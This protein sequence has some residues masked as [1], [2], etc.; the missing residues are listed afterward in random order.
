MMHALVDQAR[1]VPIEAEIERRGIVLKGKTADRCGPCPV[2]NG[3]DRFS[4]NSRKQVFHCRGC[5]VG[6]D[7]IAMTQHID[8]CAF[9]AAVET[10]TGDQLR[11]TAVQAPAA[12][13]QTKRTDK[14]RIASALQWWKDAGPITGTIGIAYL[15]RERGITEL[16]PDVHD[17]IRFHPYCIYGQDDAGQRLYVSA[18]VCLLCDVITNKPT[19]IHRI[20][21]H[22]N[23]KLIGRMG[24]GIKQ[25][26]AVKLWGDAEVA[27]GLCIGEGIET[28]LAAATRVQHRNT[29]LR[30]AW[31]LL[32]A[33]NIDSFPVLPG[34]AIEHLTIL[35]DHDRNGAGQRAART[36]AKRWTAAGYDVEILIPDVLG[37]DFNDL[38]KRAA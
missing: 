9:T 18:I 2:C 6:G 30:P 3:T 5:R 10:L 38:I 36:C 14:D 17:V 11:R 28:T 1:A 13:K 4:I 31:S 32:D 7:V 27:T 25:G 20:A 19:G 29:L 34:G 33:S 15:E 12:K 26:S 35:C 21:L 23:G 37:E 16:P 8:A 22:P 24:L